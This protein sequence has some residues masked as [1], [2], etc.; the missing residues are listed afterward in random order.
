M[1]SS[2]Q[3]PARSGELEDR[4]AIFVSQRKQKSRTF[5]QVAVHLRAL[6]AGR[7]ESPAP[8]S[9]LSCVASPRQDFQNLL[10]FSSR[11]FLARMLATFVLAPEGRSA[12]L[13]GPSAVNIFARR[14]RMCVPGV[15]LRVSSSCTS[16]PAACS[17]RSWR[18]CA[19]LK[20]S[21]RPVVS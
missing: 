21:R 9:R 18:Y 20:R 3:L 7:L 19:G 15:D 12:I 1:D 4:L 10:G 8:C 2:S 11:L 5:Q 16:L 6:R 14:R 13:S 17:V